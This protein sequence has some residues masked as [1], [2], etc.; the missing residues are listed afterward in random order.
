MASVKWTPAQS[1]AIYA[2]GKSIAVS[3]A[4]GSGKTAVLTRRI[5]ERVCAEDAS[6]DISRILVVTFTKAAASELVSRIS[7]ALADEL[8][9]N[10]ASR[11]IRS[12]SLL[13]SSA[14]ISTIH[15]FCLDLIRTNFQKLDIPADFSAA[16]EAE[17]E[18]MMKNIA[19][20]L[21]SDYFEDE[22]LPHEEKIEDFSYFADTFGDI[23]RTD[24]L[25]ET[26][27]GLYKALSS[28]LEFLN[29]PKQYAK[30]AK[31]AA[32]NG[33]DGSVWERTLRAYLI[34]FLKHYEKIYEDA[35]SHIDDHDE[36]GKYRSVFADEFDEIETLLRDAEKGEPYAELARLLG[37]HKSA[38]LPVVR[39]VAGDGKM[40]F[41]KESRSDFNKELKKIGEEYYSYREEDLKAALL[42]TAKTL[43]SR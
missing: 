16:N 36:L 39:G 2:R 43:E 20:D 4:A 32:E 6:G 21:I 19:E 31:K 8:A 30:D 10:P 26:I 35:L 24:K 15:S 28:T 18:L 13:V 33:F 23:A 29:L 17:I 11:H 40:N 14:H 5:I 9:K 25:A 12:Q 42:G 41:Y 3:A 7:D 27:I 37:N 22:L 38:R 34:D 1:D